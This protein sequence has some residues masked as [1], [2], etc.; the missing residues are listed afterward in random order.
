M[1]F[2]E[3]FLTFVLRQ[4]VRIKIDQKNGFAN[5]T[6]IVKPNFK[7]YLKLFIINKYPI[8][9]KIKTQLTFLKYKNKINTKNILKFSNKIIEKYDVFV[10]DIFDSIIYRKIPPESIKDIVS[11]YIAKKSKIFYPRIRHLR[12]ESEMEVG[13]ENIKN[14]FDADTKYDDVIKLWTKKIMNEFPLST[15]PSNQEIKDFELLIET[16]SQFTKKTIIDFLKLL[17][18][19]DNKKII[20]ISDY[21]FDSKII[22]KFLNKLKCDIYFDQGY[23]SCEYLLT[24]KSGRLYEKL[25]NNK[26]L[27]SKK[28]LMIGD[29]PNSDYNSAHKFGI[30]S[31]LLYDIEQKYKNYK[32]ELTENL[33][34]QNVFYEGSS[35][36]EIISNI[37]TQDK[38][39]DYNLGLLLSPLY[40]SFV[41]RIINYC[42]VN[43]INNIYFL[44]REGKIFLNI[45]NKINTNEKLK[46][47]YMIA[48]RKSTFL[49]SLKKLNTNELNRIWKQYDNQTPKQL[50]ENLNL[51][52]NLLSIFKQLNIK[53]D[54]I[55]DYN[56]N[57]KKL[58]L[59]LSNKKFQKIFLKIKNKQLEYFNEYC[60]SIG[61]KKDEKIALVDIG[62]KG[63]IQ[64]NLSKILKNEIHGL[65][66]GHLKTT[67]N[68]FKNNYKTGLIVDENTSGWYEKKLFQNGPL[69]EMSTTPN[70]GSC[71][72]YSKIGPVVKQYKSEKKN[73]KEY[74]SKT[75]KG[76]NNYVTLYKKYKDL[77]VSNPEN[78][79]HFSL[80][81]I[82][83]FILYP[84]N[85][86]AKSFLRYSHTESFGVKGTSKFDYKWN[87]EYV[88][89]DK[90]LNQIFQRFKSN[91]FRQFWIQGILK[92][93]HIP[94]LNIIYNIF[95]NTS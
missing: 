32:I 95:K 93:T 82:V 9:F 15:L 34:K 84:N 16:K 62:W 31:Y 50:L 76:I 38:D 57:F 23:C 64:D 1:K 89:I 45:F 72:R 68:L 29:N 74:F 73:F 80:D 20:F 48:S 33:R 67:N 59:I 94:G 90:N 7:S 51:P 8:L 81:K 79:Y 78:N 77:I 3:S 10:F 65:Y 87:W 91:F 46:G 12:Y 58:N 43:N 19:I 56:Y 88:F 66:F 26:I 30:K 25:L 39:Y 4:I 37:L 44:A 35:T 5:N 52:N 11:K 49:M 54:E 27:N 40:I 14:G 69:F 53:K 70:E 63:S 55:I 22:F 75:Q 60:N 13:Q 47:I 24:K 17:K 41:E 2:N 42:E 71:L 21:Y 36:D 86:E 61:L 28:T 83:R 18:N 92:R 6:N 85:I